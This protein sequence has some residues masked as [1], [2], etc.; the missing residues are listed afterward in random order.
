MHNVERDRKNYSDLINKGW[1][2]IVVWEC[3]LKKDQFTETMD[4][5]S[6]EIRNY[7]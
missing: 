5:L 4:R 2:V 3:E 7:K 6:E 1:N